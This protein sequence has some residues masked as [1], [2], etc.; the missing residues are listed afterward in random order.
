MA[1]RLLAFFM[2]LERLEDRTV[3][4]FFCGDPERIQRRRRRRRR[5]GG[6]TP[7]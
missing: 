7:R 1:T 4:L 6:A 5:R 2:R 3:G